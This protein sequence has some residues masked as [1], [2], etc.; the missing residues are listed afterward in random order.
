MS[1]A[2][3]PSG[4]ADADDSNFLIPNSRQQGLVCG[5]TF[6]PISACARCAPSPRSRGPVGAILISLI[7]Q[8][9]NLREIVAAIR[10]GGE[11]DDSQKPLAS[12]V[13]AV[14]DAEKYV[15]ALQAQRGI[16][17]DTTDANRSLLS[18]AADM[19]ERLR[20]MRM[21][22]LTI[23]ITGART[24]EIVGFADDMLVSLVSARDRLTRF[25]QSMAGMEGAIE[26]GA[27]SERE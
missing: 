18:I 20:Y 10:A 19:D 25:N 4:C 17:I 5:P 1:V 7:G 2:L 15:W 13:A 8:C 3:Q 27:V 22:A 16:A 11:N 9:A 21:C 24:E 26:Y 12:I 14:K 23:K 6:S